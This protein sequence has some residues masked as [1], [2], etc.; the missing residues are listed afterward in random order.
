MEPRREHE[1]HDPS[2]PSPALKYLALGGGFTRAR[3]LVRDGYGTLT[4]LYFRTSDERAT[5][6]KVCEAE[7]LTQPRD[8]L[9][10]LGLPVDEDDV[11]EGTV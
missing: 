7:G 10:R 5:A 4:D 8:I 2:A 1:R 3:Q 9:G 11:D 6:R